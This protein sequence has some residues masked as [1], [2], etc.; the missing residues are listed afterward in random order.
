MQAGVV[1]LFGVVAEAREGEQGDPV[2]G[3]VVAEPGADVVLVNDLG[4]D[5]DLVVVD[6]LLKTG[7]LQVE[8][9]KLRVNHGIGHAI[10]P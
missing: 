1:F 10:T 5:E 3:V 7:G 6:H 9:V 4:A 8:V 2:V